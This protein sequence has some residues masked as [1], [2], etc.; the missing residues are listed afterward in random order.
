M[1]DDPFEFRSAAWKLQD[2]VREEERKQ[3]EEI[4]LRYDTVH[5]RQ[6][7]VHT[8]EDVVLIVSQ[9]TTITK[10]M[11]KLLWLAALILIVLIYIAVR[12]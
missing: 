7:I 11:R 5:V 12:T 9:V 8:R 6:S 4:S 3:R 2:E 10:Q 1:G